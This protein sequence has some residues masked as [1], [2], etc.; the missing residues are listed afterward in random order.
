M[1][2]KRQ[3]VERMVEKAAGD[4]VKEGLAALTLTFIPHEGNNLFKKLIAAVLLLSWLAMFFGFVTVP[5]AMA[6]WIVPYTAMVFAV[7]GGLMGVNWERFF[8]KATKK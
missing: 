5:P 3:Q 2:L 6:T 4:P 8:P 1:K 7:V